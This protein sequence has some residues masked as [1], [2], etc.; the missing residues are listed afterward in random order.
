MLSDY[1]SKVV[2][3]LDPDLET[4]EAKPVLVEDKKMY[5]ADFNVHPVDSL[6][7]AAIDT[8]YHPPKIEDIENTL[9]V[10][11]SQTKAVLKLARGQDFYAFPRFSPDGRQ[12]CWENGITKTCRGTI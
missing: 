6:W 12:L 2:H 3:V 11:D 10:I 1:D 8:I 5:F 7:V 4:R 9:A